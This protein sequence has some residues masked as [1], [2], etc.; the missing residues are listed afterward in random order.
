[1]TQPS[2]E[3]SH[4]HVTAMHTGVHQSPIHLLR[5]RASR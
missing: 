4:T 2:L 1:M 5:Y 3:K